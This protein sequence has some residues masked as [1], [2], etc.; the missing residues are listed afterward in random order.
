MWLYPDCVLIFQAVVQHS[1]VRQLTYLY[2]CIEIW[3]SASKC[4]GF[5]SYLADFY[6]LSWHST[7]DTQ[8]S[9]CQEMWKSSGVG[10]NDMPWSTSAFSDCHVGF[11]EEHGAEA[12]PVCKQSQSNPLC[13]EFALKCSGSDIPQN[14]CF[15]ILSIYSSE[16]KA[17]FLIL[18][19]LSAEKMGWAIPAHLGLIEIASLRYWTTYHI[20]MN[21]RWEIVDNL[22]SE[23]WGVTL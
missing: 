1:T 21:M 11:H 13:C 16:L 19:Q 22:S 2:M 7:V 8:P 6:A 18:N 10:Q 14:M 17:V 20:Y 12:S 23:K 15:W 4:C 5:F 9:M 3:R